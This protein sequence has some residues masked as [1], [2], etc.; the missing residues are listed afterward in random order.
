MSTETNL[1]A[2]NA[3]Y[4][5]SFFIFNL[6]VLI[7]LF[8]AGYYK[9]I[10]GDLEKM[11]SLRTAGILVAPLV[12]FIVNG[13]L[14]SNQKAILVFWRLKD[15]LP[16]ARA[17]SVHAPRDMRID[18]ARLHSLHGD[19]PTSAKEQ[20]V[21]WYRI[22]KNNHDQITIWKSHKD[23]L[24]ARDIVAMGFLFVI[25]AGIPILTVGIAPLKWFY[26]TALVFQYFLVCIIAQNH[27]KRF[28]TNVL[29]IEAT[30]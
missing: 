29:A 25:F 18:M 19:L 4:L 3:P 2:K 6:T 26:F 10:S 7:A 30:K 12:L 28:V 16:G 23:F 24:L 1:K 8:F 9:E 22:F 27:G 21:L 14:S 5:W 11:L 20:N 13:L 15:P 17:F